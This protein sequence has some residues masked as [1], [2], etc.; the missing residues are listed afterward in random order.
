MFLF[1]S[2]G[3]LPGSI[4]A[5]PPSLL[6]GWTFRSPRPAATQ[7]TRRQTPVAPVSL[8]VGGGGRWGGSV[9]STPHPHQLAPSFLLAWGGP[10][11]VSEG[12]LALH[13]S[14]C[15]P[16]GCAPWWTSA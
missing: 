16:A 3:R 2:S 7:A 4:G 11:T 8:G 15:W 14:R 6:S 5:T 10:S 9:S 13:G 12:D 1:L